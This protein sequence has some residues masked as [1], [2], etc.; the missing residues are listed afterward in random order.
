MCCHVGLIRELPLGM[1]KGNT[2]VEPMFSAVS[3]KEKVV[4]F[5]QPNTGDQLQLQ[6]GNLELS[7]YQYQKVLYIYSFIKVHS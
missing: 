5:F 7:S 3:P 1:L 6:R 2:V 4:F